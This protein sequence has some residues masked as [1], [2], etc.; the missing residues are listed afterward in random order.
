MTSIKSNSGSI[1]RTQTSAWSVKGEMTRKEKTKSFL[2]DVFPQAVGMGLEATKLSK[3]DSTKTSGTGKGK[4]AGADLDPS[5]IAKGAG[6]L[7]GWGNI[8]G[9]VTGAIDIGMNWG[10]STPAKGAASGSAIGATIGS[11]IAPGVGTAIGGAIGAIA[12]GLLGS[13]KTGKHK[14]QKARDQVREF[15]VSNGI[16]APDYTIGLADGSRFNLGVDGGPKKELGGRRPFEVD[17]TNPMAKY[18]I[19]WMNPV[20][21]LLSQGNEK[22]HTDFVGYFANAALS[23]A[24][25]IDDVRANVTGFIKQFGLDD[26]KVAQGTIEAAKAGLIDEG[27][28]MA[29]LNGIEERTNPKV[30]LD[31]T[32]SSILAPTKAPQG[33]GEVAADADDAQNFDPQT[34]D[35]GGDI[36]VD[37]GEEILAEDGMIEEEEFEEMQAA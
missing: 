16:L 1:F 9:A 31:L 35:D 30:K 21:A 36:A 4:S 20:I 23:N 14:D 25:S 15:L 18:A 33:L 13:I 26:S 17:M 28:A 19:S 2:T 8:L 24:K 7:S 6:K 29:W 3:T 12:G 37:A 11:F 34:I 27:T 5:D 10:K 22:I 32:S